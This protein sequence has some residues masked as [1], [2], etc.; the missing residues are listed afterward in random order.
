MQNSWENGPI[1]WLLSKWVLWAESCAPPNSYIDPELLV[2]QNLLY[3]E[4]R[5]IKRQL[6]WNKAIRVGPNPI[7][8]V[9][10]QEEKIWQRHTRDVLAQGKDH[11]WTWQGGHH[12]QVKEL[13]KSG[14][15]KSADNCWLGTSNLQNC[16]KTNFHCSSHLVYGILYDSSIK[17]IQW[18]RW[19]A[20][21]GL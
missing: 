6:G 8:L 1:L 9:I 17:L 15:I 19:W 3:L 18:V 10:L 7:W 11:R 13:Y 5:P 16:E 4:I 2:S 21:Q 12:V 14:E 20:W